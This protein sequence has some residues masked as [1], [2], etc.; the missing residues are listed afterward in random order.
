LG[1]PPDTSQ[2]TLTTGTYS[3]FNILTGLVGNVGFP[4]AAASDAYVFV[5]NTY[6]GEDTFLKQ[7]RNLTTEHRQFMATSRTGTC[8][9]WTAK[10]TKLEARV[11]ATVIPV[12]T[13]LVPSALA[14]S[15]TDG[16]PTSTC[17]L[18]GVGGPWG[19]WTQT[20]AQPSA[21]IYSDRG[22]A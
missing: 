14:V 18:T 5:T 20:L 3:A 13:T 15:P 11:R 19:G 4:G 7:A 2:R 17:Y 9:G 16:T 21:R 12:T 6:K 22:H 10:F 1:G 8:S